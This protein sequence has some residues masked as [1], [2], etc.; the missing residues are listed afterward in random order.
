MYSLG[1][2]LS[3]IENIRETF[4]LIYKLKFFIFTYPFFGVLSYV[5]QNEEAL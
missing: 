2:E 3:D 1:Q 5:V 4:N